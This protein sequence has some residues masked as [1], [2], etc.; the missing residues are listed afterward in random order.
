[1]L[2]SSTRKIEEKDPTLW[3]NGQRH[4]QTLLPWPM[5]KSAHKK[6]C[7]TFSVMK[8]N[9]EIAFSTC[10][11]DSTL[12]CGLWGAGVALDLLAGRCPWHRTGHNVSK[13]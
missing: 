9:T 6:K 12:C 2:I 8:N 11:R 1:M 4:E 10:E 7:L 3:K 13:L 5:Y